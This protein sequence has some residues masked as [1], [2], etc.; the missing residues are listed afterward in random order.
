MTGLGAVCQIHPRGASLGGTR[1]PLGI[2]GARVLCRPRGMAGTPARP[3]AERGVTGA[4]SLALA[5]WVPVPAVPWGGGKDSLRTGGTQHPRRRV[6][7]P[8]LPE[9]LFQVMPTPAPRMVMV[10][11]SRPRCKAKPWLFPGLQNPLGFTPV[12]GFRVRGTRSP[13]G[14]AGHPRIPAVPAALAS[15][16]ENCP[17]TGWMRPA[18]P[19][20]VVPAAG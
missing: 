10:V 1:H 3:T 9:R 6:T 18:L 14:Y 4:D 2:R 11:P 13:R 17:G 7:P 8:A 19:D 16:S 15:S 5:A 20:R 12:L